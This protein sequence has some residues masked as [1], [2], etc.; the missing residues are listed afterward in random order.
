MGRC[1][2]GRPR[3]PVYALSIHLGWP[4]GQ[5]S[6]RKR[7]LHRRNFRPFILNRHAADERPAVV[8]EVPP[9]SSWK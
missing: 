6:L 1:P 7:P 5:V 2:Y 9:G 8:E 3:R 4:L